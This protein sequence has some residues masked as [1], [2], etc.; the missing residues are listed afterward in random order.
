MS[1]LMS[2]GLDR[3][4]VPVHAQPRC[5]YIYFATPPRASFTIT[6]EFVSAERVIIAHA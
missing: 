5:D 4:P 6:N 2:L 1:K 3:I